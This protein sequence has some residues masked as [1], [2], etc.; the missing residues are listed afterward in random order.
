MIINVGSINRIK[1]RAVEESCSDLFGKVEIRTYA[2]PSGVSH[3][4]LS[5]EA[6]IEGAI[7]RAVGAF[8]RSEADLGIGLEGGVT[9]T[10]YGPFLKG[11]VAVHDGENRF[12]GATPAIPL[13]RH[14]MDELNRGREL[15]DVMDESSGRKDVRSNEGAFGILTG[16]RITRILSFKLALYCALAPIL[17]QEAYGKTANSSPWATPSPCQ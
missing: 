12:I 8:N 11:W 7:N 17:N 9:I 5:D 6:M 14:L 10:P 3:T 15:S 16:N 1:R 4:P 2:V 13:P